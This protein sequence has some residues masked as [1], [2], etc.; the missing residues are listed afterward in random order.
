M[1]LKGGVWPW[2]HSH[3][4]NV[5]SWAITST[6][7]LYA[8]F[9]I[10]TAGQASFPSP[11]FTNA[12]ADKTQISTNAKTEL[13]VLSLNALFFWGVSLTT[14]PQS[15]GLVPAPS[16]C[17]TLHRQGFTEFPLPSLQPTLFYSPHSCPDALWILQF[18]CN[19]YSWLISFSFSPSSNPFFTLLLL[20]FHNTV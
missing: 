11:R 13:T 14:V 5:L 9:F 6:C 17:L 4:T 20:L 10:S 15:P 7:I 12:L 1:F 18:Y 3:L 8:Q 2:P 19:K 16:F